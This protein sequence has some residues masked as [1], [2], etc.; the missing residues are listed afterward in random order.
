MAAHTEEKRTSAPAAF[1]EMR[2]DL[3]ISVVPRGRGYVAVVK[4]PLAHRFYEMNP[5][6]VELARHLSS[7]AD[8]SEQSEYSVKIAP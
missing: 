8:A 5:A 7:G 1:S 2:G 6:D 4:D 3:E